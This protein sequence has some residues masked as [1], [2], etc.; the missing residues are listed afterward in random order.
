MRLIADEL[1][2]ITLGEPQ[3]F[4]NLTLFPLLRADQPPGPPEYLLLFE[5]LKSGVVEITEL[6]DGGSVPE[7][8]LR[9]LS[10]RNVLLLDGEELVGAKQ[11][12]VLN[13]TILAPAGKTIVIPVSC[14]EAGRWRHVSRQFAAASHL[15]YSSGRAI[16][17]MDVTRSMMSSRQ[18]RSDQGEV[19]RDIG[20]KASRMDAESATAAMSHIFETHGQTIDDYLRAFHPAQGQV[21]ILHA[22]GGRI[23]GLDLFDHP[24]TLDRT[25]A[26]LLRSYALDAL[27][28]SAPQPRIEAGQAGDFLRK[29]AGA[30]VYIEP[31][32]G[33]GKDVRIYGPGLSGGGLCYEDRYLHLAAFPARG[34]N[35]P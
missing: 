3:S 21:G 18:R 17:C 27:D 1:Q 26:R 12:R 33:L 20:E 34:G 14:V 11:N 29:V 22:C 19:W 5:A 35:K 9:N 2:S 8:S 16:R 10:D 7:L 4:Q 13:L 15:Q 30:P 6:S 28:H 25:F 24:A 31:A 32:I 23:T